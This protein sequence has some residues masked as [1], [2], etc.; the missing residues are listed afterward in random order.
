MDQPNDQVPEVKQVEPLVRPTI[1]MSSGAYFSFENPES[2]PLSVEDI[3]H[4]LSNICRFTGHVRHFYSVAQ[5]AYLVSK[6]I[7]PGYEYWGLHH[8][9]AESVLGDVST[10]L[11]RLLPDYKAIEHFV[12]KAFRKQLGLIPS[13]VTKKF[14][15]HAD[16]TLLAT[17]KRDLMPSHRP[18][19]P[20]WDIIKDI[21]PLTKVIKPW[22]PEKARRKYLQRHYEIVA[23]MR[24]KKQPQYGISD[25]LVTQ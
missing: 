17:E 1:Q 8:D 6:C 10:P 12:E 23:L 24:S 2:S 20:T 16:W 14:V 11:K 4:A 21:H 13:D 15:K 22:S 18:G 5:H 7:A 25:A 3:A 9:D 19:E